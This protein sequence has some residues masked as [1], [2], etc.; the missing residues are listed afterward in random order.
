MCPADSCSSSADTD[1]VILRAESRWFSAEMGKHAQNEK[2]SSSAESDP[3]K[4]RQISSHT[5]YSIAQSVLFPADENRT[6]KTL[7]QIGRRR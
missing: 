6:Q 4:D 1:T 3:K 7:K 5:V 2:P